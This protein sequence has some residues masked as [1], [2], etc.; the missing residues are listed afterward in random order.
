MTCTLAGHS[1]NGLLVGEQQAVLPLQLVH[2]TDAKSVG[3]ALLGLLEARLLDQP[4]RDWIT[5]V[6]AATSVALVFFLER[7]LRIE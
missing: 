4:L 5:T 1:G 2:S 3:K 6:G 7:R